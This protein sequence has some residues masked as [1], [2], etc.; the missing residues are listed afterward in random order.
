MSALLI[1]VQR[2]DEWRKVTTVRVPTFPHDYDNQRARQAAMAEATRQVTGWSG[3]FVGSRLRIG[4][5][6]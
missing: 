6:G 2:G 5:A 1:E 3:Y 4:E